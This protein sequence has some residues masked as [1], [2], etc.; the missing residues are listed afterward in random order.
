M[1]IPRAVTPFSPKFDPLKLSKLIENIVCKNIR[2]IIARKYLRIRC[3]R[4]YQNCITIDVVGC[5][6]RCIF[7]W[8][9]P[10]RDYPE[11]YGKFKYPQTILHEVEAFARKTG[12]KRVRLSGGEPTI[13]W[14][15]LINL[16]SL[17]EESKF[18]EQIILETNGII[19]GSNPSYAKELSK[20]SKLIVRVSIKAGYPEKFSERTGAVIKAFQLPYNAVEYLLNEGIY[21]YVALMTDPRIVSLDERRRMFEILS[22]INREL[23]REVEEECIELYPMARR[24]LQIAGIKL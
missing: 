13:G 5:N 8:A 11:H 2:G 6:L 19:I 23:P 10:S 20:F 15:H 16:L 17:L 3:A 24:R 21:V 9:P 14:S 1:S 7:C 4:F 12:I 22:S 18:I